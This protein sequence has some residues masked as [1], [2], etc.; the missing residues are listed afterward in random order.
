MNTDVES[1]LDTFRLLQPLIQVSHGIE[2]TQP[3]AYCSLS[4]VL[5]G[6]GIPKIHQE[7]I[8]EQL[9][10]MSIV[11]LDNL[12]TGGLIRTDHVSVVFGIELRGELRGVHQVAEHDRELSTLSF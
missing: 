1:E 10:D 7:T 2:D 3:R 6:L 5:M 9:G 4:V 8:P 11:A 12:G